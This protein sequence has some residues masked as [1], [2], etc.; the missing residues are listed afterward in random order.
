M[1]WWYVNISLSDSWSTTYQN[2]TLYA[3]NTA[4]VITT[5]PDTTCYTGDPYFYDADA[6]DLN[7]DTITWDATEKPVWLVVDPTN[8]QCTG[9]PVV[10]GNYDVKLRAFDGISYDYKNWTI[11]VTTY[12]PPIPEVP[13]ED[14]PDYGPVFQPR[15]TYWIKGLT[16]V[17][18]DASIGDIV[19]WQ[20]SFGDGFGSQGTYVS[21]RYDQAGTYTVTLTI[22]G[23]DGQRSTVQVTI[24]VKDD[25][26]WFIERSE[27]GWVIGTPVGNL[28]LSGILLVALGGGILGLSF[29][30]KKLPIRPK[31]LRI[32]GIVLLVLGVLFYA[33]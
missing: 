28:N 7:G 11:V 4:P 29:I 10:D 3:L 14:E 18:D 12:V 23:Q 24:T 17:V 1:G 32:I 20:W 2:Y 15:F 19:R 33:Y 6:T 31:W 13:D 5:T 25:A 9:I 22:I 21:H 30:G 26:D 27:V 16:V 8:G